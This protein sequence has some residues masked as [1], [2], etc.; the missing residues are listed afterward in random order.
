MLD[1]KD[2]QAIAAM[3]AEE[4]KHTDSKFEKQHT[5]YMAYI[6]AHVDPQLKI[7]AEG[8]QALLDRMV[9]T[10]RIEALEFDNSVLKAAISRLSERISALE[11]AM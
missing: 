4:R 7:L 5:D 10:D 8:H 1:E 11:K 3:L 9:P 2:L 6:E